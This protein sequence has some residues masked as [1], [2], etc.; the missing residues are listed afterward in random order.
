MPSSKSALKTTESSP[1]TT[2][3]ENVHQTKSYLGYTRLLGP[4][5]KTCQMSTSENGVSHLK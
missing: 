3:Q 5:P 4:R 2:E 1:G